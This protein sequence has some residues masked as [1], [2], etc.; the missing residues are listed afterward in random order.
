MPAVPSPGL[1]STSASASGP[2][3]AWFLPSNAP[4]ADHK[5]VIIPLFCPVRECQHTLRHHPEMTLSCS[6]SAHKHPCKAAVE[7]ASN[8]KEVS[9]T[10]EELLQC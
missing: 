3:A 1:G 6:T 7:V 9:C 2:G 8:V 10:K 4:P 5:G